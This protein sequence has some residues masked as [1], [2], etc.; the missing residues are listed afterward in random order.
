MQ[1]PTRRQYLGAAL[2][3]GLSVTAGC[4]ITANQPPSGGNDSGDE[5]DTTA[6]T[7]SPAE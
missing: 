2:T 7:S 6:A 1:R 4:S 5:P 3:T